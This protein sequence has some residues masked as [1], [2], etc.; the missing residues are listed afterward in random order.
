[1][2]E[3]FVDLCNYFE[4]L[5]EIIKSGISQRTTE[6]TRRFTETITIGI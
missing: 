6:E 1:M 4:L 3:F 2:N 5:C